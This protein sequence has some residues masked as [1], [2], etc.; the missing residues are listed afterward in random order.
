MQKWCREDIGKMPYSHKFPFTK[1]VVNEFE[2][3]MLSQDEKGMDK[4]GQALD[5]FDTKY[6]WL[7]MAEEELADLIKY[8][9]A[10]Q[11]K[12][13]F[14]LK[15]ILEIVVETSIDADEKEDHYTKTQMERIILN[16][17]AL[18]PGLNKKII[19]GEK[20]D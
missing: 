11:H 19:G 3:T 10:E 5:P 16:L 8:F 20:N 18:V 1:I 2:K 17:G 14:I 4:Y 12:R 9:K 15:E 7:E 13:N 6:D